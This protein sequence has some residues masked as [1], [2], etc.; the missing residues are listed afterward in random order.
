MEFE[1]FDAADLV[2]NEMYGK[3]LHG[4]LLRVD[5]G[6]PKSRRREHNTES[7]EPYHQ[8]APP[9]PPEPETTHEVYEK[10]PYYRPV[11]APSDSYIPDDYDRDSRER[12]DYEPSHQPS[13]RH[14]SYA[15][16]AP[17]Q[18]PQYH[19]TYHGQERSYPRPESF[20]GRSP[21]PPRVHRPGGMVSAAGGPPRHGY[22]DYSQRAPPPRYAPEGGY[23]RPAYGDR[24]PY[25]PRQPHYQSQ[26]Y[27]GK[28][29]HYHDNNQRGDTSRFHEG[30]RYEPKRNHDGGYEAAPYRPKQPYRDDHQRDRMPQTE[31]A[32]GDAYQERG[33]QRPYQNYRQPYNNQRGGFRRDNYHRGGARRHYDNREE[34]Q[35]QR[36]RS[37]SPTGDQ[38]VDDKASHQSATAVEEPYSEDQLL[39]ESAAHQNQNDEL[40]E[41]LSPV[42]DD[43]PLVI[44]EQAMDTRP[45]GD[46]PDIDN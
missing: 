22:D 43:A 5:W 14:E 16:S 1:S 23:D 46:S 42:N 36:R 10:R 37:Q 15:R 33:Y 40:M 39:S 3:E 7:T 34:Y 17:Y 25:P 12:R 21:P 20:R 6:E 30:G 9:P 32:S 27:S 28:P 13:S 8:T 29:Q 31:A 35:Q 41:I 11:T 38:F 24:Q 44:D 18:K 26:Q 2:L 19:D 4:R 45:R